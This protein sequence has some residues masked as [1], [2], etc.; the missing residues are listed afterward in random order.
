MNGHFKD[1]VLDHL[2]DVGNVA[3]FVSFGPGDEGQRFCRLRGIAANQGF[4]TVSAGIR[5]LFRSASSG[6][7]NIRTFHPER[8][9]GREFVYGLK[10]DIEVVGKLSQFT[11]DGL[12]CIVNETIDI[13]D[14]GVSAVCEGHVVEFAPGVTPRFV[15]GGMSGGGGASLPKD[16]GFRLLQT[17][18]GFPTIADFGD[19]WRV[20]FSLHPL[21]Q[22]HRN[23]HTIL[24]ELER[25]DRGP[26]TTSVAWPNRFSRLIG[27]KAFGLLLA[28]ALGLLVPRT[29]VITRRI[30]PFS[31]GAPT[32]TGEAW[33]R[34]CPAEQEPGRFPTHRGWT[35]PFRLLEC[36][37]NSDHIVSVLAQEGV[38]AVYAGAFIT[39]AD[40]L[41]II[42][43]TPNSGE[44]FML[45]R[46]GPA[47]LPEDLERSVRTAFRIAASILGPVR[48]EWAHDGERVW[49]LQLHAGA[50]S[51]LG[52][53]IHP[54]ERLNWIRF[55]VTNGLEALRSTI[56]R[57]N[58]ESHGIVLVGDVGITSHMAD[59]LRKAQI[60]SRI[61]L[62]QSEMPA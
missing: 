35:D 50:T 47:I 28:D 2:A 54:G 24:W 20:E 23:E 58:S 9:Q 51:S 32:R 44:E 21:R 22:G 39:G 57:T 17:V 10:S 62:E 38:G 40:G 19:E 5:E 56:E 12:Y 60:P 53:V 33:I 61:E 25:T 36:T 27:D 45:S 37:P 29:T 49:F 30:A 8:P 43:A 31:F 15:E 48:G 11:S 3:Q 59:L 34:T 46:V 7:V 14:G 55:Q 6:S 41:P 52:R 18:Y 13:E 4:P 1:S 16:V 42:E 26:K